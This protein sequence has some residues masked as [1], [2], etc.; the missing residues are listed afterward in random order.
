MLFCQ[1]LTEFSLFIILLLVLFYRTSYCWSTEQ[2]L[3]KNKWNI[4][5]LCVLSNSLSPSSP[6][7]SKLQL[8]VK[9]AAGTPLL[10]Y[11]PHNLRSLT[12]LDIS[13][14]KEWEESKERLEHSTMESHTDHNLWTKY[15]CFLWISM[16]FTYFCNRT[17]YIY[18]IL[19]KVCGYLINH[20]YICLLNIS[21]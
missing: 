20:I 4:T 18:T 2:L 15:V 13:L 19:T 17:S 11:T 14:K 6:I 7:P 10:G 1:K 8:P 5:R 3:E 12:L 9:P 16:F 21:F